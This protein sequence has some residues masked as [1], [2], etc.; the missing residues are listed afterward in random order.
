MDHSGSIEPFQ[1][2]QMKEFVLAFLQLWNIRLDETRV[3]II[4]FSTNANIVI[5]LSD[6]VNKSH[7]LNTVDN[8]IHVDG[9]TAMGDALELLQDH[10][11][12]QE[13]GDRPCKHVLHI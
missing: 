8:M 1:F 2:L 10:L 6:N 5:S 7:V 4:R 13:N 9:H 12:T 3:G 11:F